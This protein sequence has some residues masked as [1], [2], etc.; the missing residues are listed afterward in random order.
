[1]SDSTGIFGLFEERELAL[2]GGYILPGITSFWLIKRG[3]EDDIRPNKERYIQVTEST[4]F[5]NTCKPSICVELYN[6]QL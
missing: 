2:A 3:A 6:A 1:M 4:R 5:T